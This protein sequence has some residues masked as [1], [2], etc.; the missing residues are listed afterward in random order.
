MPINGR[1]QDKKEQDNLTKHTKQHYKII[2]GET[3]W[4]KISK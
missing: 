4:Q 3:K 1:L 2:K